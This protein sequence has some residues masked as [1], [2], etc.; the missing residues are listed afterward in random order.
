MGADVIKYG[1]IFVGGVAVGLFI[2]KQYARSQWSGA[3]HDGL[4]KL[5]LEG[6]VIEETAD[7]LIL[8]TVS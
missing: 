7:R 5:G 6:G 8:P 2:A 4:A 3:I 1:L